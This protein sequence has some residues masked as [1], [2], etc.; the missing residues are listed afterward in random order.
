M[1]S[2]RPVER[3][4]DL[5]GWT[6]EGVRGMLREAA[7]GELGTDLSEVADETLI[8]DGLAEGDAEIAVSESFEPEPEID[9]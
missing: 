7:L 3:A 2:G 6:E 5:A 8:V 1:M 9:A 4:A